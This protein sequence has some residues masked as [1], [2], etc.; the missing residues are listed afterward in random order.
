[1]LKQWVEE[2]HRWWPPLRVAILHASGSGIRIGGTNM[3]DFDVDDME[4][5]ENL[6]DEEY[7]PDRRGRFAGKKKKTR[8]RRSLFSKKSGKKAAGVVDQFIKKG[9]KKKKGEENPASIILTLRLL[10]NEWNA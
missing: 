5:D 9:D 4:F 2:F 7:E 3:D 1:V 10:Y 6:D 8:A